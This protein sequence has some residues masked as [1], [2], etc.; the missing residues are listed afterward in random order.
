MK[1][2]IYGGTFDPPHIG[3]V[4]GA[5]AAVKAMELDK[6]L[7][8]PAKL[9]PHKELCGNSSSPEDRLKMTKLAMKGVPKAKVSDIEFSREGRSYTVDTVMEIKRL[10]PKAKLYLFMGTDM[11][12]SFDRWRE[13][14]TLIDNCT[15]CGFARHEGD[16]SDIKKKL[17]SL[18]KEYGAKTHIV[19][20]D[21]IDISSSQLREDFSG[22]V[23]NNYV[24]DAVYSYIISKRLY[25]AK[26]NFEW[27]REKAYAMLKPK[28][29]P[30]VQGCEQEAAR[31]AERWGEC[32]E[33]A[34][35]AAILHDVTKKEDLKGQLLLCEKY[36]I[37]TDNEEK[38]SPNLLH[39]K[40]GAAVAEHVFGCSER[41]V[42][43]IMWH[44]TGRENMNLLEKIIYL[45][46]F[47]EPTR[48]FEGLSEVRALAYEDL[49]RAVE[50]AFV[51]SLEDMGNRKI[52][53]HERTVNALRSIREY[54][55]DRDI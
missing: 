22:R 26:P 11:V 41:V 16:N 31:L 32:V 17:K 10:Y 33:D 29:V 49:D 30:H 37:L 42:N 51:L 48:S 8:I 43:A 28:R 36:G 46:D 20:A 24:P 40:T 12:M 50:R 15:I 18:E 53:P 52:A 4:N 14:E 9:P 45:A 19:K 25:G 6:L 7:V 55:G 34:R 23:G 38:E 3:H 5:K 13:F 47:I 44:T 35:E 27:L 1:I 21:V 54:I 2:G 39:S